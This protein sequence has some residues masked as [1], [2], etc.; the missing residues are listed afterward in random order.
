M[1][2]AYYIGMYVRIIS[3]K[4]KDGSVVEYVQLAHNYRDPKSGYARA[5][6]IYSFGRKDREACQKHL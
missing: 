6:V 2:H 3:R 1:E 4:N 5:E